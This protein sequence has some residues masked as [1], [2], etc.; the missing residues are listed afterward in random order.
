[1]RVYRA[2]AIRIVISVKEN[3]VY[4]EERDRAGYYQIPEH[5]SELAKILAR[6]GF[7][8]RIIQGVIK[9][10]QQERE[11]VAKGGET[12]IVEEKSG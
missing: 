3:R 1:M 7:S 10:I 2:P 6:D 11:I 5:L 12:G 9:G 4:V 8:P